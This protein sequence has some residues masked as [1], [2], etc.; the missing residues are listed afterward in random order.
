MAKKATKEENKTPKIKMPVKDLVDFV[1][2]VTMTGALT[3]EGETKRKSDELFPEFEG[4]VSA[5]KLKVVMSNKTG[6]VY[7]QLTYNV[8]QVITDGIVWC[9]Y[10][11]KLLEYVTKLKMDGDVVVEF[12]KIITLK[13]KDLTAKV[14][15]V[16]YENLQYPAFA[17]SIT[18]K[19]DTKGPIWKYKDQDL[20]TV[21]KAN[22]KDLKPVVAD[23]TLM[24]QVFY[25]ISVVKSEGD[26][27]EIVVQAKNDFDSI[28]RHISS[29]TIS[30]PECSGD[31]QV[32]IDSAF[33]NLS[34][35]V[36]IRMGD[37]SP[38]IVISETEK[39]KMVLFIAA[40]VPDNEVAIAEETMFVDFGS[41]EQQATQTTHVEQVVAESHNGDTPAPN[42]AAAAAE[43]DDFV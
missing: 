42:A 9:G 18:E 24:E 15:N 32:G 30:G 22:M 10:N 2:L 29:V 7:G 19:F 26:K 13:T 17:K 41:S 6:N 14:R 37:K 1:K 25:P 4:V 38:M 34:G 20:A 35:D 5:G 36:V 16:A 31:Y 33:N 39:Y 40:R 43:D 28:E 27:L 3:V 12:D 23:G 21:I 8:A 11:G